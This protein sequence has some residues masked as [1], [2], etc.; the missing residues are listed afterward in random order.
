LSQALYVQVTATLRTTEQSLWADKEYC[1]NEFYLGDDGEGK[2]KKY[3]GNVD[4]RNTAAGFVYKG[5]KHAI[6]STAGDDENTNQKDFPA[7][8]IFPNHRSNS[9][10]A[11]PIS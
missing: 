8:S 2:L 6:N 10:N 7:S 1:A 11:S 5:S 3:C 4:I 9:H